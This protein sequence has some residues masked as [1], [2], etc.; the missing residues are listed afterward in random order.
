MRTRLNKLKEQL[1]NDFGKTT[2][3]ELLCKE[4]N[5]TNE[6]DQLRLAEQVLAEPMTRTV[7]DWYS[8]W[9]KL[10]GISAPRLEE[11]VKELNMAKL[12]NFQRLCKE[13]NATT[14]SPA[15]LPLPSRFFVMHLTV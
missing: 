3:W 14:G 4:Q 10:Y 6:A 7:A 1:R 11:L 12:L 15:L 2:R 9:T 5:V 8:C 13:R